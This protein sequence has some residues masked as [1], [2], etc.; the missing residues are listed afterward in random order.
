MFNVLLFNIC[1]EKS[2]YYICQILFL[3]LIFIIGAMII[4]FI[5]FEDHIKRLYPKKMQMCVF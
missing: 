1:L 2:L 4:Y 3:L 5:S